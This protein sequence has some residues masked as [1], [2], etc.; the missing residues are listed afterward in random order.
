M[1]DSTTAPADVVAEIDDVIAEAEAAETEAPVY[2]VTGLA[3]QMAE[4]YDVDLAEVEG[5]GKDGR[6]VVPDVDKYIKARAAEAEQA[7]TEASADPGTEEAPAKKTPSKQKPAKKTGE[8]SFVPSLPNINQGLIEVHHTIRAVAEVGSGDWFSSI[9]SVEDADE[10]LG[11]MMGEGW[12]LLK[13]QSLGYGPDGI[14]MLWVFGRF[15]EDAQTRE[16]PWREIHHITRRVGDLGDDG[17]GISG[18]AANALINGYL[19]SGWDLAAVEALDKSAGGAV[20]MMWI[21]VR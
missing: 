2:D 7:E 19:Q 14:E 13:T 20:N 17:R 6:I 12:S 5:T 4:D 10:N 8:P 1:T 3:Q 9:V 21:L 18:M 16:W 11:R 15:D